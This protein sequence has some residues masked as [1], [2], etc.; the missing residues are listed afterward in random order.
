MLNGSGFDIPLTSDIFRFPIANDPGCR[1]TRP[2]QLIEFH[3]K[4]LLDLVIPFGASQE[5]FVDGYK[6]LSDRDTIRPLF[7]SPK[8]LSNGSN[9]S[10]D[11]YE[12]RIGFIKKLLESLL[13]V[14]ELESD[15]KTVKV[16][17]FSLKDPDQWLSPSNGAA[18]ILA[19]AA[20][21][22]NLDCLFCYNKGTSPAL[23]PEPGN[24][25]QEF[26]QL[27]SRIDHY[28]PGS[29]LNLFPHMKS[30]GE[31]L[32]H[33]YI[34]DILGLLRRKTDEC[35]RI[36]TNGSTLTE[37]MINDLSD[38]R[39][40]YLD[41]S[42]N[43]ASADRRR[44][45]MN[46]RKPE[47]ALASLKRLEKAQ[48]P[49]SLV[50]VPWP[51][52]STDAMHR[53]LSATIDFASAHSPTLVQI[54]LPGGAANRFNPGVTLTESLWVELADHIR[55]LR[56][57]VSCPMVMRPGLFEDYQNP[58]RINDPILT[59]VI[60]NSP[61]ARAGLRRGDRICKINGFAVATRRQARLLLTVLHE[62]DLPASAI[63][64]QRADTQLNMDVDLLQS[65]YPYLK[66]AATHLGAVFSHS[67]I[68]GQWL[69]QLW[70]TISC[71]NARQVLVLT[72]K[73]IRPFLEKAISADGRFSA[74][75][76][77]LLTP[78]NKYFG[79]NI[80]MGDLLVVEDFIF[81][82]NDYIKRNHSRPDLLVLPSTPFHLSGWGRDLT[83]RVYLDIQRHLGIATALVECDPI[84]D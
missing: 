49:Y 8:D 41:I 4:A 12:P 51:Y 70:Q 42:I 57:R 19:H 33:P 68:P 45:L 83:G 17:G 55:R 1:T 27:N 29:R 5:L 64:V 36:S 13:G 47:I 32:A 52:P 81:A 25:A 40:V 62:S 23:I 69:D 79:G 43:S 22:C 65:G 2:D 44:M 39:P 30:P 20:T 82:V 3:L 75:D 76:L 7:S 21:R 46:D 63:S 74:I 6:L 72:S 28:V 38:C 59:G 15:G 26:Q 56:D 10:L 71:K 16:D 48:I 58:D 34:R 50:I 54:S 78:E 66:A 24:A 35:F 18:D 84:F 37:K 60:E 9:D 14:I 53:D 73:L 80:C 77:H 31:S 67:G 11:V 61:L